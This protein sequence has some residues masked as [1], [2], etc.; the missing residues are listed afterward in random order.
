M[1][2]IQSKLT[3]FK[4]WQNFLEIYVIKHFLRRQLFLIGNVQWLFQ[5]FFYQGRGLCRN[6][7]N[8][9]N[10]VFLR[11]WLAAEIFYNFFKLK[12]SK[13]IFVNILI[14]SSYVAHLRL[15]KRLNIIRCGRILFQRCEMNSSN[16][17]ELKN[18]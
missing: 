15:K 5:S 16:S 17:H 9:Y 1:K 14:N 11:K 6:F 2:Y 4:Y 18:S 13:N 7:Q 3:C 12:L 10:W 8:I